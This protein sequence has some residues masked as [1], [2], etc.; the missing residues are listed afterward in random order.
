MLSADPKWPNFNS[1]CRS[2]WPAQAEAGMPAY[3]VHGPDEG[4]LYTAAVYYGA[5]SR[6]RVLGAY[7]S[8]VQAG[9]A[10]DVGLLWSRLADGSECPH[11]GATPACWVVSRIVGAGG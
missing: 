10:R 8:A 5:Y 7:R 11:C 6:S 9:V 4:G 2:C 1:P 3:G